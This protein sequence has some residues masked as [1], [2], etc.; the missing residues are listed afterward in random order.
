MG[1]II[2]ALAGLIALSCVVLYAVFLRAPLIE[3]DIEN[4]SRQLLKAAGVGQVRVRA[5]GRE[6]LL[7]GDA[8]ARDKATAIAAE[9]FG[10]VGVQWLD[11]DRTFSQQGNGDD[12]SEQNSAQP[13]ALIPW[14]TRLTLLDGQLS[15]E[16]DRPSG[17][18]ASSAIVARIAADYGERNVSMDAQ[19]T[20][21]IP[22]YWADTVKAA[23]K[24]LGKMVSGSAE[25]KSNKLF[26][27]GVVA[28]D[29]DQALIKKLLLALTPPEV[30][31][32][33]AFETQA[34][35]V[36]QIALRMSPADCDVRV[37]EFMSDKRV[38]FRKSKTSLQDSAFAVIDGVMVILARCPQ[39]KVQIGGYTD[40]RGDP[41]L[42]KRLSRERAETVREYLVEKGMNM[43][44]LDARG[45]GPLRPIATNKTARGRAVNRRIE[46]RVIGE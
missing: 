44:R 43:A 16:G 20:E 41:E 1:R 10:V 35:E 3:R 27:E 9:I 5:D 7:R 45:Y 24:A 13:G 6:L 46:F 42:N 30:S 18:R 26:V 19:G 14:K 17:E 34:A 38:Q 2:L 25:I 12:N 31:W 21:N 36:R 33:T 23:A 37:A 39:A 8:A 11:D 15:I 4:R 32:G 40:A 29:E 28:E 22:V